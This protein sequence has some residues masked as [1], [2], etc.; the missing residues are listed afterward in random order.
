MGA[1]VNVAA[2]LHN[3]FLS[4]RLERAFADCFADKLHTRLQGGADEPL[5][6]PALQ[7]GHSHVL[8]YRADY[9]ASALHEVAHW[10]IAGTARRRQ[11]DFGYW[12]APDGRSGNEQLASIDLNHWQGELAR[13]LPR[14]SGLV[15]RDSTPDDG[16][17]AHHH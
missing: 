5:Y 7:Q 10:C 12:Y 13:E 4:E 15:C 9:F 1:P 6:Q 2:P 8:H 16:H 17:S 11:V 3:G 14:G